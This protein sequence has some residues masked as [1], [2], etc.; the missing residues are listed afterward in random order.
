MARGVTARLAKEGD[1]EKARHVERGEKRR[2][3]AEQEDEFILLP[4]REK[5]GVFRE[6]TTE[7]RR[8]DEREITSR[9]GEE[10]PLHLFAEAAHPP[11][12][13]LMVQRV[14]DRSG[15]EEEQCLEESVREKV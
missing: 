12:V 4:G 14:D 11:D 15:T 10:S 13:L 1:H 6:E 5:D 3:Q 2:R 9:K 7:E 8:A